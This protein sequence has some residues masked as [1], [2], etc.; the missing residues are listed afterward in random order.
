MSS[1]HDHADVDNTLL[2]ASISRNAMISFRQLAPD[3]KREHDSNGS[4]STTVAP[5]PP[6]SKRTKTEQ[7]CSNCR[8]LRR[9]VRVILVGVPRELN[10]DFSAM[11]LA[12]VQ[13][14]ERTR[15]Q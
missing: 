11:E 10:Y 3:R 5:T 9:K 13:R 7:A 12:R 4:P 6:T 2:S 14:V 15:Y 8:A 1:S